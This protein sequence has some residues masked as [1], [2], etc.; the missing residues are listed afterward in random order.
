MHIR[1]PFAG[2]VALWHVPALILVGLAFS[3]L[4]LTLGGFRLDTT[5]EPWF[6]LVWLLVG[7]LIASPEVRQRMWSASPL[8]VVGGLLVPPFTAVAGA[9]LT[10]AWLF[11]RAQSWSLRVIASLWSVAAACWLAAW[12]V[13][14]TIVMLSPGMPVAP[15][16]MAEAVADSLY[17]LV[18]DLTFQP[19]YT[20]AARIV[21]FVAVVT[22]AVW[23]LTR[24]R[25]WRRD[26]RTSTVG[27]GELDAR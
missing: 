25:T 6:T 5:G 8:L 27:S 1:M 15:L 22:T 13:G 11:V 3:S 24:V 21:P 20:V 19:V 12:F 18:I 14:P 7:P 10:V 16:S 4:C 17:S 9:A 26:E 2:P 23:A